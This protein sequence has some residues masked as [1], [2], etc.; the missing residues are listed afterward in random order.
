MQ[1]FVFK[2]CQHIIMDWPRLLCFPCETQ[3]PAAKALEDDR[4]ARQALLAGTTES[5]A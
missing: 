5:N 2:S 3:V 1:Q 4:D